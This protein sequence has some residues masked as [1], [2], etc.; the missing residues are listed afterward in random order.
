[1]FLHACT[2]VIRSP[3]VAPRVRG[4]VSRRRRLRGIPRQEARAFK[5]VNV[6]VLAALAGHK[7]I[8]TTQRYIEL[9]ENV[10]RAAVE[11]VWHLRYSRGEVTGDV[12][13]VAPCPHRK[14]P[15][16]YLQI[17]HLKLLHS[18][19]FLDAISQVEGVIHG[20]LLEDIEP[21]GNRA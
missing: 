6:R 8:A 16:L 10:L 15:Q 20:M 3:H 17:R 4:A 18:P 7:R 5:G 9:N 19:L 14:R 21:Q 13:V 11:M 12:A 2:L 1:M